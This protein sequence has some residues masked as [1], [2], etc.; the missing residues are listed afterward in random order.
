VCVC[1]CVCVRSVYYIYYF[2]ASLLHIDALAYQ[3]LEDIILKIEVHLPMLQEIFL[4]FRYHPRIS[5][6]SFMLL[7]TLQNF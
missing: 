7:L 3:L 2:L 4:D 5:H 6:R 1:V